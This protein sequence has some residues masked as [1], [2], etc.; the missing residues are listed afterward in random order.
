MPERLRDAGGFTSFFETSAICMGTEGT[1]GTAAQT[2]TNSVPRTREQAG[3]EWEH[4]AVSATGSP[5]LFPVFPVAGFAVGTQRPA[6]FLIVP[7]VPTVP[8]GFEA[9]C[10]NTGNALRG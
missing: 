8:N 7:D 6:L 3:N 5:V 2:P 9:A 10:E 4:L 1:A